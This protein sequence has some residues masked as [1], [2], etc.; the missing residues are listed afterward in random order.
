M[1]CMWVFCMCATSV[2]FLQ[3]TEE[4]VSSLEL[5]LQMPAGHHVDTSNQIWA[6]CKSNQ[7]S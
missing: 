5:E 2:Q 6:L 3:R 4:G 1:L 7:C